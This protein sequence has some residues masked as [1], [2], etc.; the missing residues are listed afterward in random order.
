MQGD[1]IQLSDK[2]FRRELVSCIRLN[3]S[4]RRRSDIPRYVSG[5]SNFMSMISPFIIKTFNINEK[6]G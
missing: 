3:T 5:I 2:R 4:R 1:R 6:T